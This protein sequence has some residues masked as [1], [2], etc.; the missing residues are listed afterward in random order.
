M[1]A[2]QLL[3]TYLPLMNRSFQS[4]P[5]GLVSWLRIIAASVVILFVVELEKKLLSPMYKK[6]KSLVED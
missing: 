3:F 4:S 5:V 6:T 1:I 2:L